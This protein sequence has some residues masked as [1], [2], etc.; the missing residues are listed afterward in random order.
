[1][2]LSGTLHLLGTLHKGNQMANR[3]NSEVRSET[4][5]FKTERLLLMIEPGLIRRIDDYRYSN[6]ISSRAA[7]VRGLIEK[8][9]PE[10]EK[11][12]AAATASA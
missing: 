12:D 3:Q 9:L 7:A 6:R 8:S 1:M 4:T 11:A 2:Y 5:E 10:I